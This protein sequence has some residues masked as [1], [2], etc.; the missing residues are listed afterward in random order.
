MD[1]PQTPGSIR[2]VL[3]A[4]G[5]DDGGVGDLRLAI[6]LEDYVQRRKRG[7]LQY[8]QA[9]KDDLVPRIKDGN[10]KRMARKEQKIELAKMLFH[11]EGDEEIIQDPMKAV[12]IYT[13][14]VEELDE[15]T[16]KK[17]TAQLN[18]AKYALQ[19]AIVL[20]EPA[21]VA[22][23]LAKVSERYLQ[24]YGKE[25]AEDAVRCGKKA[26]AICLEDFY[27]IDDVSI[28][29]SW[30]MVIPLSCDC[31]CHS[32][33]QSY[34]FVFFF[35]FLPQTREKPKPLAH[36]NDPTYPGL[37]N[38][39][40]KDFIPPRVA[41]ICLRSAYLHTGN[42]LAAMGKDAEACEMY[43]KG[44]PIIDAEHRAARVDWER[45]SYLIN[46]GNAYSREGNLDKADE[47]YKKC[48]KIGDEQIANDCKADG[49]GMK[50]VAL[51]SRAFALNRNG[52]VDEGKEVLREVLKQQPIVKEET[53]KCRQE[54][55]DF[56]K[57]AEESPPEAAP[58][59]DGAKP[60]TP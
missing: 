58:E 38:P 28:E 7:E 31:R 22:L 9:L 4:D 56:T 3:G 18:A 26:I 55:S 52:K 57:L 20:R 21:C 27:D 19:C 5:Y 46:I 35:R 8:F 42:A 10:W 44:Y 34:T 53:E 15:V 30:D 23:C 48:E 1:K 16:K 41:S 37:S 59:A 12:E 40:W 17:Y 51:R 32:P 11:E 43:L 13:E 50:L 39:A 36:E 29:V 14:R 54:M 47:Y 49:M 24:V 6:D 2:K 33:A 60:V 45:V 25:G